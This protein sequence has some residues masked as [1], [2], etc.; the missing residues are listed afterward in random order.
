MNMFNE[1]VRNALSKVIKDIGFQNSDINISLASN[2]GD[3]YGG[4]LYRIQ[5]SGEKE[6]LQTTHN[7]V[8]KVPIENFKLN[9]NLAF[10]REVHV[11]QNI[12]KTFEKFQEEK[13]LTENYKFKSYVHCY[14]SGC[15]KN[16]EYIIMDDLKSNS[17][18]MLNKLSKIDRPHVELVVKALAEFHALSFALKDQ[19]KEVFQKISNV[20]EVLVGV[21]SERAFLDM[22]DFGLAQA[23]EA[24]NKCDKDLQD[25]VRKVRE[26]LLAT[27][28]EFFN[29]VGSE[30]YCVINHAD[31]WNNNMMFKYEVGK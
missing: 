22:C 31:C 16:S 18:V 26:N 14:D 1:T 23:V 5:I 13:G 7:L 29:G 15:L 25:K 12:L 19:R 24:L 28:K 10:N 27:V 30:D 2:P 9:L 6:G 8:C 20:P 21:L 11:Y 17:Y 3:N 4:T